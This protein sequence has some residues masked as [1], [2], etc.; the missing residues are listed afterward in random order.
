MPEE[1]ISKIA[2]DEEYSAQSGD[3][4]RYELSGEDEAKTT[5]IIKFWREDGRVVFEKSTRNCVIRRGHTDCRSSSPPNS[6]SGATSLPSKIPSR[7]VSI[8]KFATLAEAEKDS[9]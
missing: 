4:A 8:E 5:Y 6:S 7:S 3:M 9:L 2:S 1:E